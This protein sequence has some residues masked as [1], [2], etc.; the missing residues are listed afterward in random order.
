MQP[1]TTT[2]IYTGWIWAILGYVLVKKLA[3]ERRLLGFW[4]GATLGF[5]GVIIANVVVKRKL[6]S[7]PSTHCTGCGLTSQPGGKFCQG[8]GGQLTE[9][10]VASSLSAPAPESAAPTTPLHD[11]HHHLSKASGTGATPSVRPVLVVLLAI[12]IVA[13]AVIAIVA[14]LGHHTG[15]S[16]AATQTVATLP[17]IPVT[18][19]VTAPPTTTPWYPADFF[20]SPTDPDIAFK[21]LPPS[22]AYQCSAGWPCWAMQVIPRLGCPGGLSVNV[23]ELDANNNVVG[24]AVDNLFAAVSP[25]QSALLKPSDISGLSSQTPSGGTPTYK[26]SG[27]PTFTCN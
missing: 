26:A 24:S 18:E 9:V 21:F 13:V 19:P 14:A 2:Y 11:D 5:V 6:K 10:P 15:T 17:A 25:G 7:Q 16:A 3:P 22:S 8:C 27:N 12:A 23:S 20:P 1:V 4:L